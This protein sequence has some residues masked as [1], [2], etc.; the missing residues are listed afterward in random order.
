M[1]RGAV[2]CSCVTVFLCYSL[3]RWCWFWRALWFRSKVLLITNKSQ[4][5]NAAPFLPQLW[6]LHCNEAPLTGYL[7]WTGYVQW[8]RKIFEDPNTEEG[9]VSGWSSFF[10]GWVVFKEDEDLQVPEALLFLQQSWKCLD[11][12]GRPSQWL[13]MTQWFSTTIIV[14]GHHLGPTQSI[15]YRYGSPLPLGYGWYQ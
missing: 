8:E 5:R 10:V 11:T 14:S 9:D 15:G 6:Y 7:R 1:D 13:S 2:F 12:R 3:N 4:V